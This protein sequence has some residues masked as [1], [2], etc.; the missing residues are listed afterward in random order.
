MSTG[1]VGQTI[2][3]DNLISNHQV[4]HIVI[5]SLFMIDETLLPHIPPYLSPDFF[6]L[7]GAWVSL[8][9][10]HQSFRVLH[11]QH[12]VTIFIISR[13]GKATY[14]AKT[15]TVLNLVRL[16]LMSFSPSMEHHVVEV[17]TFIHG[18]CC[19]CFKFFFSHR[20]NIIPLELL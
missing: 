9:F 6:Y 13:S 7:N 15:D 12:T 16:D 14:H 20:K 8:A 3:K 10:R 5:L 11:Q 4:N 17:D 19:E 1:S 2:G 18:A